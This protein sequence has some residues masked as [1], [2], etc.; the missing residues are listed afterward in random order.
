MRVVMPMLEKQQMAEAGM[1]DTLQPPVDPRKPRVAIR[2]TPMFDPN[3]QASAS[4]LLSG[5]WFMVV[6]CGSSC[7]SSS[8]DSSSYVSSSCS[9]QFCL[10]IFL[11]I[12]VL[13]YIR[14]CL[15]DHFYCFINNIHYTNPHICYTYYTILLYRW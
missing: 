3:S 14:I 13:N 5:R 8:C 1:V 15:V 11:N 4:P 2:H 7:V 12:Y 9:I 6:S 10:F